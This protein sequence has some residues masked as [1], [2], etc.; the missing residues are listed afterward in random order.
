MTFETWQFGQPHQDILSWVSLSYHPTRER[1]L[2]AD[3]FP[4]LPLPQDGKR[5]SSISMRQWPLWTKKKKEPTV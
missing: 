3:Y 4:S 1:P 5:P 2:L